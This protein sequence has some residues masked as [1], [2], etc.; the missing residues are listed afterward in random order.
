VT[1]HTS[2]A[3]T[4]RTTRKRTRW[5]LQW[6]NKRVF[7]NVEKRHTRCPKRGGPSHLP[8]RAL[9]TPQ[10]FC[11]LFFYNRSNIKFFL[12]WLNNNK[13]IIATIWKSSF[14]LFIFFL[15]VFWLFHCAFCFFTFYVWSNTKLPLTELIII[16][17]PSW[18]YKINHWCYFFFVFK[19]ILIFLLYI[20]NEK[21]YIY[22]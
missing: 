7:L 13:K 22:S 16:K 4:C 6:Q 8:D 21:K 12:S 18:K 15:R 11:Y 10:S 17:K 14:T 3:D 19:V 9:H 5:G 20:C 1:N 2:T